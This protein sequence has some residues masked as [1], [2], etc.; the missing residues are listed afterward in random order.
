MVNT[1]ELEE[2]ARAL[3][4]P[5]IDDAISNVFY[6]SL[7]DTIGDDARKNH[8]FTNRS[9]LTERSIYTEVDGNIGSV[10]VPTVPE[11]NAVGVPYVQFLVNYDPFLDIAFDNEI[12][13][14]YKQFE[15]DLREEINEL[16]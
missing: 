9:F 16:Y 3:E 1:R 7:D 12:G 11:S 14:L 8:A 15:R 13:N 10:Y 4:N 2:F 6:N 5:R